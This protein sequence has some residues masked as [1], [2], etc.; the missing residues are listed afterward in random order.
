MCADTNVAVA[1]HCVMGTHLLSV[2][3]KGDAIT[4]VMALLPIVAN[5]HRRVLTLLYTHTQQNAA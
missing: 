4:T 2:Q 5:V 1:T 3:Q